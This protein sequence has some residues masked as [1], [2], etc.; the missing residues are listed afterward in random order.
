MV[1]SGI[2]T[3]CGG[4]VETTAFS[5]TENK[6]D[7]PTIE[8]D[9][10]I[11]G[12]SDVSQT[13]APAQ[14]WFAAIRNNNG[15][16]CGGA[17]IAPGV[18]V[19]AAHCYDG[20]TASNLRVAVGQHRNVANDTTPRS[21][22]ISRI[23]IHKDY[24]PIHTKNDI[25]L[26][27]VDPSE[28][29]LLNDANGKSPSII[30]L[31]TSA[32]MPE[33]LAG[34]LMGTDAKK[35]TSQLVAFGF[36]NTSNF[37]YLPPENLQQGFL[38]TVKIS[39]CSKI[40]KLQ[41]P[42]N[43]VDS[44]QICAGFLVKGGV[45]TCQGDSGGPLIAVR[46]ENRYRKLTTLVGLTSYGYGCALPGFPGVYT[47]VA[48]FQNW[49][50]EQL[51]KQ[52]DIL[53]LPS[54]LGLLASQFCFK[55]D[56]R[57]ARSEGKSQSGWF[58]VSFV[59]DLLR[60]KF[61][62]LEPSKNN[63]TSVGPLSCGATIP[64]KALSPGN[65]LEIAEFKPSTNGKFESVMRVG[66]STYSVKDVDAP[67]EL[68]LACTIGKDASKF[69]VRSMG[70]L[71]EV[72][73]KTADSDYFGQ[74]IG[75][76]PSGF[77]D[78][79]VAGSCSIGNVTVDVRTQVTEPGQSKIFAKITVENIKDKKNKIVQFI[80]ASKSQI[81]VLASPTLRPIE[82]IKNIFPGGGGKL[83]IQNFARDP[84]FTWEL[85][86]N[87]PFQVATPLKRDP[88]SRN[89]VPSPAWIKSKP[90]SGDVISL[91]GSDWKNWNA[92][93]FPYGPKAVST[94]PGANGKIGVFD[95]IEL[96]LQLSKPSDDAD[97]KCTLNHDT[98]SI[99]TGSFGAGSLRDDQRQPIE[100]LKFLRTMESS[101]HH[102]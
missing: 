47:R 46:N 35:Q 80:E 33:A 93:K 99:S 88:M 66:K 70:G 25:A 82:F 26:L 84:I 87:H 19:S 6:A 38:D 50:K 12:G 1:S 51:G 59:P 67:M 95:E 14:T 75:T 40:F 71:A 32:S 85:Q 57:I 89:N 23:I 49:I 55:K 29:K 76:Q 100:R 68:F 30:S 90:L 24:E 4:G 31:E 42:D 101:R 60:S 97:F 48:S 15:P 3:A 98:D 17:F 62:L 83:W 72:I 44:S 81:P 39:E 53:P 41:D 11:V 37:G 8:G 96:L 16:M 77:N 61:T 58:T 74:V 65:L 73:F 5:P 86:C 28:I 13:A 91:V 94:T 43:N 54:D 78:S 7:W 9:L 64:N 18:I 56:N 36:G 45:D 63:P 27:I 22:K 69:A 102:Q 20:M 10:G 2:L 21:A 34:T 52:N 92:V 79:A